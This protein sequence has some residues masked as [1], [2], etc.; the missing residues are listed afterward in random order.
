MCKQCKRHSPNKFVN[1]YG[2]AV[3]PSAE[4]DSLFPEKSTN[5]GKFKI[6]DNCGKRKQTK[7]VGN[8]HLCSN[9]EE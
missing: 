8:K 3:E 5:H 2:S 4:R 1:N 7:K 9:C 6:C